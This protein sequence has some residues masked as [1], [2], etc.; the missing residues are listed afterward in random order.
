MFDLIDESGKDLS[1]YGYAVKTLPCGDASLAYLKVDSHE[2]AERLG[3][4]MGEY[5]IINAQKLL[6]KDY[7]SL[8]YLSGVCANALKQ[9]IEQKL[10]NKK[11]QRCLLVGLGNPDILADCLG[12]SV[13]DNV[14]IEGKKNVFKFCPNIYA[15]TNIETFDFVSFVQNGVGAD[16]IIVIDSL[17]TNE[18]SRLGCSIQIT[19][20]GIAAGSGVGAKNK[21]I[22]EENL[23]VPCISIGVPFMMFAN[24]LAS[25][26]P[27]DLLLSPKDIHENVD[28]MAYIIGKAINEMWGTNDGK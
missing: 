15:L 26:A 2:K 9:I 20:T 7:K 19:S 6:E 27:K 13:L 24:S 22:C 17:A 14:D 16:L 25:D 11:H 23:G 3:F 5:F 21:R 10:N 1:Q 28:V 8:D 4:F 12:K 18:I